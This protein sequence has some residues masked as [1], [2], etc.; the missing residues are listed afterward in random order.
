MGWHD[1]GLILQGRISA[2][3]ELAAR[4]GKNSTP[5][6]DAVIREE[7]FKARQGLK[8]GDNGPVT[9]AKAAKEVTINAGTLRWTV[10]SHYAD[11]PLADHEVRDLMRK[12]GVWK[13]CSE[14]R[15]LGA[16][17]D[18][19]EVRVDPLTGRDCMVCEIT[20][21]GASILALEAT[22]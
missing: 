18:T 21:A 9:S 10:L 13:R 8:P 14:L 17:R 5:T 15:L 12:N 22:K 11:R 7:I 6:V 2:L 20:P 4:L 3:T 1:E 19:G 16:I